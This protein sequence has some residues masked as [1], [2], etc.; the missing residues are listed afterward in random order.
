MVFVA[1]KGSVNACWGLGVFG[2]VI[3]LSCT[4]FQRALVLCVVVKQTPG[5]VLVELSLFFDFYLLLW[6][7]FCVR[8]SLILV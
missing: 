5:G 8:L 3:R 2:G 7:K 4:V 6:I 1:P